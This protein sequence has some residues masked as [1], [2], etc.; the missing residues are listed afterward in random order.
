MKRYLIAAIAALSLTACGSSMRKAGIRLD[1]PL[2]KL[3]M[4]EPV[5]FPDDLHR[6]LVQLPGRSAT[7]M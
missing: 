4:H 5:M 6:G 1:I 3:P 2:R 7:T